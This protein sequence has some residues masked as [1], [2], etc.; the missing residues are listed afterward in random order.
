MTTFYAG[1]DV[2]Q[3]R[4]D[5][6]IDTDCRVWRFSNDNDGFEAI[7]RLFDE[8]LGQPE[9][10]VVEASGGYEL[11]L[12]DAL[13][14]R[15]VPVSQVNPRCARDFAKATGRLQKTDAI[16][17]RV[18]AEFAR[19]DTTT[20]Y[21]PPSDHRRELRALQRQRQRLVDTRGQFSKQLAQA[22]FESVRQLHTRQI[23]MFDELVEQLEAKIKQ[24][25]KQD[26]QL[27]AALKRLRTLPGVG[28]QTALTLMCEM[29]ELGQLSHKQ[30]AKLAGV[31]PLNN[32][33]GKH[34][35][36]ASIWGGRARLRRLLYMAAL[37]AV[38][39]EGPLR[40]HYRTLT[41]TDR[42]CVDQRGRQL[43]LPA[44]PKKVALV[45]IMRKLLIYAN[46]I[47][48]DG[49]SWQPEKARPRT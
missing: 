23:E 47:V 22:Q 16:D 33:S 1:C 21:A 5:V 49:T 10:L 4:L 41:T 27:A 43:S 44:R 42:T 18:L 14:Q 45:A 40:D 28:P 25:V 3:D 9:R 32:D 17:A 31:A 19:V 35:G 36:Q 26:Q 24:L 39:V 30:A 11:A 37:S 7:A 38:R 34:R 48:R 6:A 2:S 13:H 8:H 29:P 12:C 15:G 46:A 20:L